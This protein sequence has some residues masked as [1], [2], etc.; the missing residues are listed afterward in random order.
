[1]KK[2]EKI[3]NC[4]YSGHRGKPRVMRFLKKTVNRAARRDGKVLG[5]DAPTHRKAYIRGTS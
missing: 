3:S 2:V 4:P 5:D 1:M